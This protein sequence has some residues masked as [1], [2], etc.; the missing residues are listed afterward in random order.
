MMTGGKFM[1]RKKYCRV[2]SLALTA[3][4]IAVGM[5][6]GT[7]WHIETNVLAEEKTE[8]PTPRYSYDFDNNL[9]GAQVVSR[10]VTDNDGGNSAGEYPHMD[11]EK[12][13]VYKKGVHNQALYLD[14]SYGLLLN[15]EKMGTSYTVSFWVK[16]EKL[17]LYGPMFF[18]G[19]DVMGPNGSW[20]NVTQ[21]YFDG[22]VAPCI[23]TYGDRIKD[24]RWTGRGHSSGEASDN[25]PRGIWSHVLFTVDGN[26][27]GETQGTRIMD[28]YVNGSL[29]ASGETAGDIW[30]LDNTKTYLGINCWDALFHG[31]IDDLEIYDTSV[32]AEQVTA[33]MN[34]YG[35]EIDTH[36]DFI[37]ADGVLTDYQ[38]TEKEI[39]IPEGVTEISDNVFWGK[40]IVSVQ[41]PDTVKKIGFGAFLYCDNLKE[42]TIPS[43]VVSMGESVV[44][45]SV[46]IKCKKNSRAYAYHLQYSEQAYEVLDPETEE[47]AERCFI[48]KKDLD[49]YMR[50]DQADT[51]D[52][53]QYDIQTV[54]GYHV[55]SD[56]IKKVIL[57]N[58]VESI[59]WSAFK[60]CTAVSEVYIPA[61]VSYIGNAAFDGCSE[62]LTI[63]SEAG[64]YAQTFAQDKG[65][66][67]KEWKEPIKE[68]ILELSFDDTLSG[69]TVL[70][71]DGDRP[72][73]T[74]P[75]MILTADPTIEETYVDGKH[76][77]ALKLD[78]S[79]AVGYDLGSLGDSYTISFWVKQKEVAQY[80]SMAF[81][82]ADIGQ[83][84]FTNNLNVQNDNITWLNLTKSFWV[85]ETLPTV[86]SYSNE[87]GAWPWYGKGVE[88]GYECP[89]PEDEW[90]HVLV[91][92]NG[93]KP[94]FGKNCVTSDCY[95]D[96]QLWCSGD[97][98]EGMFDGDHNYFYLGGNFWDKFVKETIDDVC[99]YDCYIDAAQA[100]RIAGAQGCQTVE[101][102]QDQ[103]SAVTDGDLTFQVY[104]DG[105]AVVTGC[106]KTADSVSIP[107]QINGNKV[108]H[109]AIRAFEN[110]AALKELLLPDSLNYIGSYA[111]SGCTSLTSLELPK[112]LEK[113]GYGIFK[114]CISLK[115]V[116]LHKDTEKLPD[117]LFS[118]CESLEVI[119]LPDSIHFAGAKLLEGSHASLYCHAD[120]ETAISLIDKEIPFKTI[121]G[122]SQ[123][124]QNK[125]V[126][127]EESY[128]QQETGNGGFRYTIKYS[129]SE[130]NLD[131]AEHKTIQIHIPSAATL[132]EG[133]VLLDG[134][135]VKDYEYK[136]GSTVVGSRDNLLIVPITKS[137]GTIKVS[138]IPETNGN[139]SSFARFCY[140]EDGNKKEETIGILHADP[141][142]VTILAD[143]YTSTGK[144]KVEGVAEAGA[145]VRLS[146]NDK[147]VKEITVSKSGNYKEELAISE[148]VNGK[149]YTF[150]AEVVSGDKVL[151][152]AETEVIY[153]EKMPVL[154]ELAMYYQDHI[155]NNKYILT[156]N[157]LFTKYVIFYPQA[158]Y[159][160][161]ASFSNRERI[162]HVYIVSTRNNEKKYMEAFWDTKKQRYVASG[163]FD[164]GNKNYVPGRISVEYTLKTNQ[165]DISAG[166]HTDFTGDPFQDKLTATWKNTKV[167]VD[168]KDKSQTIEK[169]L[170][171]EITGVEGS[172]LLLS[173]TESAG[174][175]E[176]DISGLL[177]QKPDQIVEQIEDNGKTYVYNLDYSHSD[178]LSI[179]IHDIA[180]GKEYHYTL[181]PSGGQWNYSMEEKMKL[182][183][184]KGMEP[185]YLSAYDP[186][187][188]TYET[189]VQNI[190]M[191]SMGSQEMDAAIQ[192]AEQLSWQGLA[193][194]VIMALFADTVRNGTTQQTQD[195]RLFNLM[196]CITGDMFDELYKQHLIN[197]L[198]SGAGYNIR[199]IIDPSG[200][201]YEAVTGNR[202]E[203]VKTTVYYKD[204]ETG[205]PIEWKAADYDQ[206]NPIITGKDGAYAWD[207][208]AGLWQVKYEKE[209]YKT[210][211]SE[212]MEVP[213]PQTDVNI[214]MVSTEKPQTVSVNIYEDSADICFS[215]YM[216]PETIKNISIK[217]SSGN[218]VPYTIE[219]D[220][221]ETSGDGT[222]Y[223]KEYSLIFDQA[224]EAGSGAYTLTMPETVK[225]YAGT[226]MEKDAFTKEF[227]KKP[228]LLAETKKKMEDGKTMTIPVTIENYTKGQKLL[229]ESSF[230]EMLSVESI[231]MGKDGKANIK[232]KAFM[233]GEV[234]LRTSIQD[235]SETLDITVTINGVSAYTS[236]DVS[237]D[238]RIDSADALFVLKMAASLIDGTATQES[239][240]DV[241]GDGK[242]DSS[243]ALL[244]L[245]YAAGLVTEW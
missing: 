228:K 116:N 138:L 186:S 43:S 29:I 99:I 202:L 193:M 115:E 95:I 10:S 160:F 220:Q 110:C 98:A 117:R 6:Q 109:I 242:V 179:T 30:D 232:V 229:C 50:T 73:G 133:S 145:T 240:A 147:K 123:G 192:T 93:N 181:K 66:T 94:G 148:P 86:W 111:F 206:E 201:V 39:V 131:A 205:N 216:Q 134:K 219:Y 241:N 190:Y 166:D 46:V 4:M 194:R 189:I 101:V 20:L 8:L 226:G 16:P 72:D 142:I 23:W 75:Q 169:E 231:D 187:N 36:D 125:Y 212:W 51:A 238:Q 82:A 103:G 105:H 135:P 227:I 68:P 77:K 24:F 5:P 182:I 89:L 222:V 17:E 217:D 108:T 130:E 25:L 67:W 63:F 52:L 47:K 236:G 168:R 178:E 156:D 96:G 170:A 184:S 210:V 203:G 56:H 62:E 65:Y 139:F 114:G 78:G 76:G 167:K 74:N 174:D 18:V 69:G 162:D 19:D 137:T 207:V 119:T 118:E 120:S 107:S 154:E 91:T 208:P 28:C 112:D 88:Q 3:G 53:S 153:Q 185:G 221:S 59:G 32:D 199:W 60:Q 12:Q 57:P 7:L 149:T 163:S 225:N 104:K 176:K 34:R 171:K 150:K 129:L 27:Q 121:G 48:Y 80:G 195:Q 106:K 122:S 14:G 70:S 15:E 85:G 161:T 218:A 215:Q 26:S 38:G 61:S 84:S 35:D 49:C 81:M 175:Y 224:L 239:A 146:I 37:I 196:A 214:A 9:G 126:K 165:K 1:G 188:D 198:T 211:Y 64:S 141:S 11:N 191:S 151:A 128:L 132:L 158:G 83:D 127:S 245:K 79:Y 124:S 177:E 164:P 204:S 2:V 41:I 152:Q 58:T 209:G 31:Y 13:A 159:S 230:E 233:P 183:V 237:A 113:T 213:P 71:R 197:L 22:T 223:A 97:I 200:Y 100:K 243:D 140:T 180:A 92:V 173:R 90:K 144:V 21:T 136:N 40:D 45:P 157:S 172:T 102:G 44:N 235:T 244:I 234:T 55:V 33:I 155:N 42:I 54:N 143:P 87:T